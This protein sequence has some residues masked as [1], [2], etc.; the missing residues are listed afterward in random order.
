MPAKKSKLLIAASIAAAGSAAVY[1]YF[2]GLSQQVSNPQDSAKVVPDEA[3]MAAFI[4]PN[5]QA[6]S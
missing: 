2:Q 1:F 3:M 4:S 6:L 5:P